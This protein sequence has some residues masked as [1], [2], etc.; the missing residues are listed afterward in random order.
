MKGLG[1]WQGVPD[2]LV[3]QP[4]SVLGVTINLPAPA[5]VTVVNLGDSKG[6]RCTD[7]EPRSLTPSIHVL[8]PTPALAPWPLGLEY[9]TK[10]RLL[11]LL[12]NKV[13]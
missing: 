10:V 13:K 6:V 3:I 9:Q 1:W 11:W 12:A 7:W 4:L 2:K 8:T 5:V